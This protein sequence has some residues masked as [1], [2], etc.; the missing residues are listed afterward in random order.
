MT[1]LAPRLPK[2]G[3]VW[4]Q[5]QNRRLVNKIRVLAAG[6]KVNEAASP[7]GL[8]IRRCTGVLI[9]EVAQGREQ[10]GGMLDPA[11]LDSLADVVHQHQ[12]DLISA[13]A[14]M[15]QIARQGRRG[16]FG[17]VF[18]LGDGADLFKIQSAHRDTVFGGYH[19][20]APMPPRI[21]PPRSFNAMIQIKLRWSGLVSRSTARRQR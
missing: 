2:Q 13:P 18:V 12:A 16:G 21:V 14:P 11:A 5:R 3:K 9:E 8:S 17:D 15:H 19:G 1:G 10:L 20:H 6:S 7:D 4:I